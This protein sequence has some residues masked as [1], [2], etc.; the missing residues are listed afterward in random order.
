MKLTKFL[1]ST[2]SRTIRRRDTRTYER[3]N[4]NYELP[5]TV[6]QY[7]FI[8]QN[9]AMY[10]RLVEVKDVIAVVEHNISDEYQVLSEKNCGI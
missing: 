2:T 1:R 3:L 8:T 7:I 4:K 9:L 10:T 6:W 5:H